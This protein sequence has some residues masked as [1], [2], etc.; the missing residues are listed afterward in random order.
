VSA[1]DRSDRARDRSPGNRSPGNRSPRDRPLGDRP[2]AEP[3]TSDRSPDDRSPG[4][5]SSD[6]RL[7]DPHD[8][9]ADRSSAVVGLPPPAELLPAARSL[10]GD[11]LPL[12]IEYAGLL[13]TD[14]VVRGLTGPREAPRIWDRHILN[15]AA[16]VELISPA[17]SV[18]D[19]GS[20]AGLPGIV[21]AVARPD[22]SVILV[23]PLA[24]RTA[25]LSEV[26]TALGL[27][28]A[29]VVRARAEECGRPSRSGS[30]AL[31]PAD[32]VT[33]RAL[34]PLDRLAA[35]C[36]PLAAEGGRVL[37][38][39]GETAGREIEEHRAAIA[40]L[41][42]GAPA[43]RV[44]GAGL[45]DPPTTVVEIV[46]ASTVAPAAQPRPGRTAAGRPRAD[47]PRGTGRPRRR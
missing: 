12:A 26:V 4:D 32:I 20:G 28:R 24:R 44:C 15:C 1:S 43:V 25:F 11:R 3:T 42:G 31:M 47:R 46:R 10:F 41:G 19:V 2:I 39:K 29:T 21:L 8:N 30:T 40:R 9:G 14:G 27:D 45:I 38:L 5:R 6:D 16:I 33:A 18:V 34:A 35:W 7:P 36:L 37:A 17:A 23:E 22:L 13:A